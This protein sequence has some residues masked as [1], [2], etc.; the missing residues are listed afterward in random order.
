MKEGG[1][2]C[3]SILDLFWNKKMSENNGTSEVEQKASQRLEGNDKKINRDENVSNGEK[4]Q[5]NQGSYNKEENVSGGLISSAINS[6]VYTAKDNFAK[7]LDPSSS[8]QDKSTSQK[9]FSS[10]QLTFAGLFAMLISWLVNIFALVLQAFG[11]CLTAL[12]VAFGPITFAFAIFPGKAGNMLSWFIRLC[13]YS[14]YAPIVSLLSVFFVE[15]FVLMCNSGSG[16]MGFLLVISIL[17]ANF[18]LLLSTPTLASMIIEGAS[19]AVSLSQG[20][21]MLGSGLASAGSTVAG[22][23]TLLAG[24]DNALSNFSSGLKQQGLGGFAKDAMKNGIG[25][26]MGNTANL[27]HNINGQADASRADLLQA[28]QGMAGG[29]GKAAG[30]AGNSDSGDLGSAPSGTAGGNSGGGE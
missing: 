4:P 7:S 2:D 3:T 1:P 21:Q 27:G 17:I 5:D 19:G 8:N 18:V 24:K 14:L 23:Y 22:G 29:N 25:G 16:V 26:A 6:S 11:I 30:N 28:I 13:Q 9:V 12:I 15:L 20:L 10:Y